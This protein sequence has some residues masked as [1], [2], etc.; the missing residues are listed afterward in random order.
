M[1]STQITGTRAIASSALRGAGLI[2]RDERMRDASD[3][4]GGR[5]GASKHRAHR[6]RPID[7]YKDHTPG[8]SRT[9]MLSARV[10]GAEPLAIRGAARPTAV[11]RM[12]RNAVSAVTGKPSLEP[13]T[14][15]VSKKAVDVWREFVK[16]RYN[17]EAQFLNLERMLDDDIIRR[18]RLVPPGAPGSSLREASVIFKLASQLKPEVKTVSL[19]NNNISQ[20][21]L[22]TSLPHY[23]PNLVNL[24]L[25]NNNLQLWRDLDNFSS[26]NHKMEQLQ[27]LILIGNPLRELEY[28]NGRGDKYRGEIGRRFPSLT[29]LDREPMTVISFDAPQASSSTASAKLP[30]ATT[31]PA[32]MQG[33][34]ITGVEPSI[35]SGF[36]ARF[37]STYDNQRASLMDAYH[38]S[39][40]FS[41]SANT[42]IPTRAR[43]Q[44]F[45]YSKEMP[46][47]KRL[48]WS[49]WLAGGHGGSRNLSRMA[50]GLDKMVKSLHVGSEEAVRAMCALPGS[51]HDVAGSP[52]KFCVDAWPV[53]EGAGMS[54][55]TSVHGQFTEQPVGGERSFDRSFIL[56]PAPEGSRAKLNGWDVMIMSDQLVV[57]SYS[58]PEAWKPGPMRVQ[59]GDPLPAFSLS[60]IPP[61]V[62]QELSQIVSGPCPEPQ[63]SLVLQICQRTGLNVKFAVECLQSNGWDLDRAVKN[64][65]EVK[66]R[67]CNGV[68]VLAR[69][70]VPAGQS[71]SRCLP[72]GASTS[73][74]LR[75]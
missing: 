20:G 3:K 55:F 65:E 24:S 69:V 1:T 31:F 8:P 33:S 51:R 59:H 7:A 58:S 14:P 54:L 34:F 30:A 29:V 12:R 40:T 64:F 22:L 18:S 50:G 23:L 56:A 37:F 68:Y 44:G 42:A 71:C 52:E 41:F 19:A 27:E 66:V 26:R 4:P 39:A 32:D 70:D 5:K 16:S 28:K 35:V 75:Y 17:A 10:T 13:R 9:S 53:G 61:E 46:N 57:R 25:E 11:G 45:Q 63:R 47:Q 38:P 2:D 67:A 73:L 15:T 48:E 72:I 49:P 74:T 21:Q 6:P 36:L 62:Q 60:Q 43:M